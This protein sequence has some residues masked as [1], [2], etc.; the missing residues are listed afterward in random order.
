M[1]SCW[2]I[3][4]ISTW[5]IARSLFAWASAVPNARSQAES[6]ESTPN[7]QRASRKRPAGE[8]QVAGLEVGLNRVQRV[9]D[10]ARQR[11]QRGH[12]EGGDHGQDDAVLGHRL[13]VLDAEPCAE[14]SDEFRESHLRLH[15]PFRGAPLAWDS[16]SLDLCI[17]LGALDL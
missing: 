12:D 8:K 13:A 3:D 5:V 9:R 2:R 10:G 16:L 4:S 11:E 7:A 17:A 14:V 1:S 6:A 15:L